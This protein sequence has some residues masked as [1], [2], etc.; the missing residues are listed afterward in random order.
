MGKGR[1]FHRYPRP[2]FPQPPP[3]SFP[4]LKAYEGFGQNDQAAHH[5]NEGRLVGLAPRRQPFVGRLHVRI[6]DLRRHRRHAED[7][8]WPPASAADVP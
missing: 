1:F 4:I 7:I 5:R 3:G 6:P 8:A 2:T